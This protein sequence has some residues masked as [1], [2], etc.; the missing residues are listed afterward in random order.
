MGEATV[1]NPF[2]THLHLNNSYLQVFTF[3]YGHH[4]QSIHHQLPYTCKPIFNN[5]K[6]LVSFL[7]RLLNAKTKVNGP[8]KKFH[9]DIS[10]AYAFMTQKTKPTFVNTALSGQISQLAFSYEKLI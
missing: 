7:Y 2:Q 4:P 9:E 6:N 8:S 5:P 1:L 3:L 10:F